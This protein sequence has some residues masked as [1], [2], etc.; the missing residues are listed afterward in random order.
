MYLLIPETSYLCL[1]VCGM[2]ISRTIHLS[3]VT[4]VMCIILVQCLIWCDLDSPISSISIKFENPGKLHHAVMG[5]ES[6]LNRKSDGPIEH[7]F[8][9]VLGQF[10]TGSL[11][12]ETASSALISVLPDPFDSSIICDIHSCCMVL[13]SIMTTT[14]TESLCLYQYEEYF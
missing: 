2:H 10:P 14:F 9:Y 3:G 12:A 1:S 5:R 4:L 8:F 6:Y 7:V 13:I 11:R